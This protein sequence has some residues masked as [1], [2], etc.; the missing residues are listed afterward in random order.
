MGFHLGLPLQHQ[1]GGRYDENPACKAA[2]LE[3]SEDQSGLDR[4]A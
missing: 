2:N 3:F 1:P 4:F